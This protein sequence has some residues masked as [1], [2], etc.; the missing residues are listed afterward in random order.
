V[1]AG[2]SRRLVLATAV[3]TALGL[4]GVTL[5]FNLVLAHRLD[6]DAR[7]VLRTR[8]QAQISNLAVAGGTIHVRESADDTAL[9]RVWVFSGRHAVERP[10]ASR[11]VQAGAETL[12]AA[13]RNRFRDIGD[14]RLLAEPVHAR[15]GRRVG[16]VV[17][18]V[19]LV[20][21]E[22]T[23]HL[24]LVAS[25]ILDAIIL[26]LVVAFARASVGRALRPV[27]TMT[28]QAADWSEHDLDR[29]FAL[30]PPRDE[31]TALA[32]TLDALLGRLSASLRH[33]QRF[34]AEVAHEL[35]TPLTNLRVQTDIALARERTPEEL[36]DALAAVEKQTDRMA[37]VVDTLVAAAERESDPHHG[38]ADAAEAALAA[39]RAY[40]ELAA[41]RAVALE[42]EP[43]A[44][45]I[46][47]D[48]DRDFAAQILAPVVENG[49]RYGR[50]WVRMTVAREAGAVRFT[51]ADD[52]PGVAPDEAEAVF[53][54]GARGSAADGSRGAGL[55]LALAR[56]L[57]RSAG[58]D[59]TVE[60]GAGGGRFDVRLP[61]S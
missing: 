54:P 52:G 61:A 32:A 28:A 26:V 33:E 45:P 6:T 40:A 24:A 11:P 36:R 31:L 12:I 50:S 43:P 21:Y 18:A 49:L 10:L 16:T 56:R 4:A 41:E 53:A 48:V 60:P 59:V 47:V 5:A 17:A 55:G 8:A 37:A 14:T 2:I 13:P 34:S 7:G 35:R 25:L 3:A 1:P 51:I 44:E 23:A 27:A 19:S 30:G 39:S 15:D 38:T 9:E 57:A 42:V 58:G 29:R 46:E 20:P 22:H